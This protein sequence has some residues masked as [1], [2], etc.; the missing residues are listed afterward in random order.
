[1]KLS[2][3]MKALAAAVALAAASNASA[4]KVSQFNEA[5]TTNQVT[6]RM[7]GATAQDAGILLLLRNSVVGQQF[8]KPNTLDVY[9]TASKNNTLYFCTGGDASGALNKRIAIFKESDGGSG[10][11]VAPLVR[12]G[13]TLNVSDGTTVTRDWL[14][15]AD[16]TVSA[17]AGTAVSA[18]G[19]FSGYTA[20]L[21]LPDTAVTTNGIPD[22]GISDVEPAQFTNIYTPALT[23][24][25]LGSLQIN[26][27]TGVIFGVP[28]TKN[29]YQRLQALQ[30]PTSSDCHPSNA[31]YGDFNSLTSVASSEACM[32]SLSRDLVAGLYTGRQVDWAQ[33]KSTQNANES[34][35]NVAPFGAMTDSKIYIQRRVATSGTQ[36]SFEIFFAGVRCTTGA[37]AFL[38][39]TNA[40]V[41]ENSG[42][43]NVIAGL[44]AD[45]NAGKGS[46]GT[47]TTE[48]PPTA[49][50]GW[51][52]IKLNGAAPSV[53]NVVKGSYEFFFES[54]IQWRKANV[55][56]GTVTLPTIT[57]A[58]RAVAQAIVTQLGK[59]AV[60][61]TLNAGFNHV[62]GRAGLVGNAVVNSATVAT[63]PFI[64]SGTDATATND[65]Y[66]RPIATSTR[67]ISG[68]PN[69][70]RLTTKVSTF[71][72]AGQ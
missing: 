44:N 39:K 54:T 60:V 51:R 36:R 30:F 59:P 43:S 37:P 70:C 7:S 14:R 49:S 12:A 2:I 57:T 33:I 55:L 4:L 22:V 67:G 69:A 65:V 9:Q 68:A 25:E 40:R 8:C 21:G 47:L 61:A 52:L 56:S 45:F 6:I 3:P 66:N 34:V 41:T 18:S 64:A 1:M 53:L 46:I 24:T 63:T 48:K 15:P 32:P 11:G 62:F 17:S 26:G 50:D 19:P 29:V 31:N 58:K 10:V 71:S 38:S 20:H 28:V 27:I 16:P 35:A 42:T 5:D 13:P 23:T 72:Q